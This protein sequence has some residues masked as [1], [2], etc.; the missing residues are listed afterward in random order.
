MKFL[1]IFLGVPAL[2]GITGTAYL[3]GVHWL[4]G[5]LG[6]DRAGPWYA[7]SL[8]GSFVLILTW[9]ALISP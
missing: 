1:L 5:R 2:I 8:V 4:L 3:L 6:F 7:T 9:I